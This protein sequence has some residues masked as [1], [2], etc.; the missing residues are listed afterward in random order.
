MFSPE[1]GY[2]RRLRIC[3][4]FPRSRAGPDIRRRPHPRRV[5]QARPR[6]CLVVDA[7]YSA[8]P[9]TRH[10]HQPNPHKPTNSLPQT[11]LSQNTGSGWNLTPRPTHKS[12]HMQMQPSYFPAPSDLPSS[13]AWLS[14]F[15]GLRLAGTS[16]WASSF[17][18]QRAEHSRRPRPH[19]RRVAQAGPRAWLVE[20][21]A[22]RLSRP[23][24]LRP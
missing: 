12:N 21:L 3:F 8:S 4:I 11:S 17:C 20:M 23:R 10:A 18:D 1:T 2:P 14:L 9:Q 16:T 7:C 13:K 6:A 15:Q 24:C 5:A 19:P 22:I